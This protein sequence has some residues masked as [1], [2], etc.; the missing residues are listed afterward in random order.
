MNPV[1]GRLKHKEKTSAKP[2]V[3][4]SIGSFGQGVQFPLISTIQTAWEASSQAVLFCSQ[5]SKTHSSQLHSNKTGSLLFS[6]K[7]P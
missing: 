2:V 4:S 5:G 1:D 3:H 7:I 6:S